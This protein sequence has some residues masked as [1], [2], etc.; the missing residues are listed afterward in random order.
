MIGGDGHLFLTGARDYVVTGSLSTSR[1]AGSTTAMARLQRSSARYYQRP[2]ATHLAF[3]PNATM[4]SG[5]SLQTDFNRNNG[6]VRPNA[7]YW[8]VSPGFEVNDLGYATSADRRGGHLAVVL[9]KQTPDRFSRSRHLVLAKW[10][11]WNFAGDRA[12][13]RLLRHLWS[14][15][16]QLLVVRARRRTSAAGC[17]ATG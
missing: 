2:D 10:N 9:L 3:D 5:W 12:R 6:N 11:T 14:H 15:A 13:R 16:A 17:T 4:L 1:V 8:A 7:S